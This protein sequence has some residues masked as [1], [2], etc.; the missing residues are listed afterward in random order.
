M[1]L[2]RAIL[3][4]LKRVD[5]YLLPQIPLLLEVGSM[6]PEPP[7][8]SEFKASLNELEISGLVVSVRDLVND[9][10][11][12]KLTDQGKANLLASGC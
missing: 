4:A 12:W 3:E 11:K 2:K 10:V 9:T 6:L 5:P 1:T 7:T 8:M